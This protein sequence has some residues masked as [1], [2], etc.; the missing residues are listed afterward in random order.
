[1]LPVHVVVALGR[2]LAQR[3][4]PGLVLIPGGAVIIIMS[5]SSESTFSPFFRLA[6]GRCGLELHEGCERSQANMPWMGVA[7]IVGERVG[8]SRRLL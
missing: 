8:V 6:W 1:M 7:V 3:L 5:S 2:A 4:M